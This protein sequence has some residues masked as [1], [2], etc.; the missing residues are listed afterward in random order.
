MILQLRDDSWREN[1]FVDV[2]DLDQEIPDR[3][4]RGV[5]KP[6]IQRKVQPKI[7]LYP[8]SG[9]VYIVAIL[10]SCILS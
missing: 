3:T 5:W 1:V 7:S 10:Y 6:F 8:H 2:I 9:L 4:V